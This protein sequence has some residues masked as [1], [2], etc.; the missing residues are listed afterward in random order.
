MR[1]LPILLFLPLLGCAGQSFVPDRAHGFVSKVGRDPRH[2]YQVYL[3]ANWDPRQR[4]PV[5]VYLHG[6]GERG[7]DGVRPTQVGLGPVVYEQ[8]GKFPFVV[9]FPQ[10]ERGSFWAAKD[11]ERRVE[12][13]I[14]DAVCEL[15]GDP[16]RI[17][18]TGNSMGGYGTWLFGARHP[19]RFAALVPLCGGVVPPSGVKIP[20]SSDSLAAASDPYAAAAQRIAQ[21]PVW[22]FHGGSDWMVPPLI[23]RKMV[24]ALKAQGAAPRHT[25]YEG[26]G[27]EVERRAYREPSL[28]S[29]LLDQRSQQAPAL[30]CSPR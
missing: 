7:D 13:A 8:A 24:A 5:I 25:E 19:G 12:D 23:T 21:T 9:L 6:G 3:P 14:R 4:W 2:R 16:E 11:M 20:M 29:W 26:V 17:Y 10:C 27:H 28:W 30:S 22:A 15:G 1:L 18:L